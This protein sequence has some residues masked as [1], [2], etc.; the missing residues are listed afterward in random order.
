MFFEDLELDDTEDIDSKLL[1]TDIDYLVKKLITDSS[2]L[3][4][5]INLY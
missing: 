1:K 2:I 5:S 4:M 3:V